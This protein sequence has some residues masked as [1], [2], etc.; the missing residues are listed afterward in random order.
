[1]NLPKV[2]S[3]KRRAARLKIAPQV[4]IGSSS[5]WLRSLLCRL[6]LGLVVSVLRVVRVFF[7]FSF[8]PFVLCGW[9][10]V[11][12]HDEVGRRWVDELPEG[13]RELLYV[14]VS[15]PDGCDPARF[16]FA[17]TRTMG[18]RLATQIIQRATKTK[19]PPQGF[20]PQQTRGDTAQCYIYE[21]WLM[22]RPQRVVMA[23]SKCSRDNSLVS[24][25]Q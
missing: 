19:R 17:L 9:V 1:M 6:G 4:R 21:M 5:N 20:R 3:S 25:I 2:D 22:T 12:V 24:G 23:V 8:V 14:R 10:S 7:F 11:V 15:K 13:E 18:A 16:D